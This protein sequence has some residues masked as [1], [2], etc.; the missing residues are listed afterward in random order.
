MSCEELIELIKGWLGDIDT[1]GLSDS[2]FV[3]VVKG[4]LEVYERS[5]DL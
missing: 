2:S 3:E 1:E 4:L 5:R